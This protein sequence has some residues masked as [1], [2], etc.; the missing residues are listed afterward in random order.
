ME[1]LRPEVE[2]ANNILIKQIPDKPYEHSLIDYIYNLSEKN[3]NSFVEIKFE[4]RRQKNDLMELPFKLTING[5][6][7]SI[8]GFLNNISNERLIRVDEIRIESIDN[9]NGLI[10]TYI[11]ANAFYK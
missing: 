3:K 5:E 10:S 9:A 2:S 7:S 4:E 11:T 6:Y 8:L 1:L